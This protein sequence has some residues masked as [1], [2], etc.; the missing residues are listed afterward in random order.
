VLGI[1]TIPVRKRSAAEQVILSPTIIS[2]IVID[3]GSSIIR[4]FSGYLTILGL[5]L[6]GFLSLAKRLGILFGG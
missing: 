6:A 5:S 4:P 2:L 3:E 1:F